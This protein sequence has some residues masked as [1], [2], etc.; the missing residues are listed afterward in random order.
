MEEKSISIQSDEITKNI[1]NEIQEHII[2]SFSKA[3]KN[4]TSEVIEKI[5]PLEKK[6]NDLKENM[7]EDNEDFE[8]KIDGLNNNLLKITKSIETTMQ[9]SIEKIISEQNKILYGSLNAIISSNDE[10]KQII[11]NENK[12]LQDKIDN[13]NIKSVKDKMTLVAKAIVKEMDN[14][15]DEILDKIN[16]EKVE[17]KV[18]GLEKSVARE[19]LNNKMM[20]LDKINKVSDKID[21]KDILIQVINRLEG[22]LITKIN[23]IQEEVEWGNKSFFARILGRKK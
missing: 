23:E 9:S 22:E 21:Q 8:E 7:E 15:K 10:I 20:V 5:K 17:E 18:D 3:S 12:N 19:L 1:M 16:I 11:E 2:D 4:M 6:I 13:I 14:N